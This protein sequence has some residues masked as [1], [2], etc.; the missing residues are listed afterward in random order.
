MLLQKKMVKCVKEINE[1]ELSKKENQI[2]ER[3]NCSLT[4]KTIFF[5]PKKRYRPSVK[6]SFCTSVW[7][8]ASLAVET[9]LV[10]PLFLMGAVTMIS[11]MD[12]YKVQTEHLSRL[13]DKVKQAGMYAYPAGQN[14]L[15]NIVLPDIYS[16]EPFGGL[17]PL[18]KMITCNQV[19]V[20]AWVG[21]TYEDTGENQENI[22][23]MVYIS[24]SGNV[25]HKNPGCSY[26][27]V[28]LRQVSGSSILSMN[29]A[30][31]E[32]YTACETCSRGQEPAGVVYI[33]GQGNR[34]HN[35]E[36]CSGLKRTVK[37][38]KESEVSGM[39]PCSRCG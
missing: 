19:K 4:T 14:S 15:E 6:V 10:L 9:A 28:S 12:I 26:L 25:Y 38:V 39:G 32:H 33:T 11:F 2:K 5:P 31:G 35:L 13:C 3:S 8:R 24:E 27:N 16:Y 34:Y 29:N 23:N 18:P 7:R 1:K 21:K 17:V 36:S 30:H 20:H 37:L 22:E